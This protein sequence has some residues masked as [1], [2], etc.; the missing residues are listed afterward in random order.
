MKTQLSNLLALA[1][2]LCTL[3][4]NAANEVHL[5]KLQSYKSYTGTTPLLR[6]HF[7][8]VV[9]NLGSA[10][11]VFV[12]MKASDGTWYNPI[13]L[14]YDR[15][16]SSG[17]EVWSADVTDFVLPYSN[18]ASQEFVI[19][20]TVNGHTYWDNNNGSNF[21]IDTDS[22]ASLF[23]INVYDKII[24]ASV[25]VPTGQSGSYSGAVTVKNLAYA[26]QVKVVYSTDGWATSNTATAV[27]SPTYWYAL[28]G[29][30]APNPN[31]Y[32]SEEWTYTLAIGPTATRLDYAVSYTVNGQTYWDNN[33]GRNYSAKVVRY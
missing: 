33:F 19:G 31:K 12:R 15:A 10:K 9:A 26:K 22:G 11:Q 25:Y 4:A 2:G 5:I 29:S 6:R 14:K 32:G 21:I 13:N 8:A 28:A 7:E 18:P 17:S 27:F 20:Y 3:S 24:P 30:A 1:F 23:G 16:A